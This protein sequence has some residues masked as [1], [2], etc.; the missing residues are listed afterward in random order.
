MLAARKRLASHQQQRHEARSC[1]VVC[2]DATHRVWPEVADAL[3]RGVD[4]AN[5]ASSSSSAEMEVLDSRWYGSAPQA[6]KVEFAS[7]TPR[8]P[9]TKKMAMLA[10]IG[11]CERITAED[12]Y[13]EL[14]SM[15]LASE[16]LVGKD[17]AASGSGSDGA[18][19]SSNGQAH[20][21]RV[22]ISIGVSSR[23]R[24]VHRSR[25]YT[26]RAQQMGA[27]SMRMARR[28]GALMMRV[29]RVRG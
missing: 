29:M 9:I 21:I 8:H 19:S 17:K 5:E 7:W 22:R 15:L 2:L 27:P 16:G 6:T 3:K 13:S 12:E 20:S 11:S 24:W 10:R 14:A 4:E 1:H 26:K 28:W 23:R 18:S 25:L